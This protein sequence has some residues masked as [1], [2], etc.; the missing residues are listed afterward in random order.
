MSIRRHEKLKQLQSCRDK[1]EAQ[2][3]EMQRAVNFKRC[4]MLEARKNKEKAIENYRHHPR[5]DV[6]W[7]EN[8]R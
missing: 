1:L 5:F 4:F 6:T 7:L 3:P 8:I 2:I